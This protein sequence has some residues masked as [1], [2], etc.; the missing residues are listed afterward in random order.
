MT[1]QLHDEFQYFIEHQ[2][3]LVREY[4]DAYDGCAKDIVDMAKKDQAHTH[5]MITATVNANI[6]SDRE[7]GRIAAGLIA[8]LFVGCFALI[9]AGNQEIGAGGLIVSFSTLIGLYVRSE[10]NRNQV[11]K[12]SKMSTRHPANDA[13]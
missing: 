13:S 1:D 10:H 6:S 5:S 3:E 12:E 9:L 8:L 7:R 11:I 2:D 4:N